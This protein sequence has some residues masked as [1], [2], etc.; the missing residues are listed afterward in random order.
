MRSCGASENKSNA[1]SQ[2]FAGR[3]FFYSP[4]VGEKKLLS[5]FSIAGSEML[6]SRREHFLISMKGGSRFGGSPGSRLHA[7]TRSFPKLAG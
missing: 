1:I 2:S 5:F 6:I 7:S 3:N 4:R